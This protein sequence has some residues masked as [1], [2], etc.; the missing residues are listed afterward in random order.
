MNIGAVFLYL[1]YGKTYSSHDSQADEKINIIPFH[2]WK[3]SANE[4]I[5]IFI[6]W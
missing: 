5:L 6:D 2:K 3:V 4:P 1:I